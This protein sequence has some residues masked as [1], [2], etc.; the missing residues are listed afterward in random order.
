MSKNTAV[1]N[2]KTEP[3]STKEL[4]EGLAV[5]L[6]DAECYAIP[7]NFCEIDCTGMEDECLFEAEVFD[8]TDPWDR[9]LHAEFF[10]SAGKLFNKS[11]MSREEL[12]LIVVAWQKIKVAENAIM[13][14]VNKFV[15]Q[16]DKDGR[17]ND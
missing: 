3:V 13:Q 8:K 12:L 16:L 7:S 15:H 14:M 6:H 5:L 2:K 4:L 11:N 1:I 17:I 10:E 9:R